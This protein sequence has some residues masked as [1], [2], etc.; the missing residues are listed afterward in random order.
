MKTEWNTI[1]KGAW[2]VVSVEGAEDL[3]PTNWWLKREVVPSKV[4]YTRLPLGADRRPRTDHGD[5][6]R[7]P[8]KFYVL[9]Q[10]QED[11]AMLVIP[12]AFRP[13]L[14]Q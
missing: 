8:I 3:I 12:H 2:A 9:I 6:A 14:R 5:G 7:E 1:D 13:V 4:K 10:D 11:I